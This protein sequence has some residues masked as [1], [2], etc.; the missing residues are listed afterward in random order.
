V[1]LRSEALLGGT[2]DVVEKQRRRR[3]RLASA[4]RLK[5]LMVPWLVRF[6]RKAPR[7]LALAPVALVLG[8]GRLLYFM[9]GNPLRR[10]AHDMAEICRAHGRNIA[11]Q[12]I[13]RGFLA[14]AR[15]LAELGLRLYRHGWQ[16]VIEDVQFPAEDIARIQALVE[17]Y[18][19]VAVAVPHNIGSTFS[20]IR[21]DKAFS[22]VL[23]S[24]NSASVERT[25]IALDFFE[26]LD[27]KVLM[28][29]DGSAIQIS[30]A[31]I[32]LLRSK[33][34]VAITMDRL[35]RPED[36]I[37]AQMFGQT[38]WFPGWASRIP[39]KVGAPVVP[40]YV[41]SVGRQLQGV[42]GPAVV[43]RDPVEATAQVAAFLERQII[44][45]P[46]SWAFLAEK[47]WGRVL[48][49]AAADLRR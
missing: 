12:T 22:S 9:P 28:V 6:M 36:G 46:A 45:D 26:R 15:A 29:R 3:R 33:K 38:V 27:A 1:T 16:E 20:G 2:I 48:A 5:D 41:K 21:F 13:Y 17:Q 42:F 19:G 7:P 35:A 39:T 14:N 34:V 10:A 43:T 23:L 24:K 11:P 32:K 30:R 40:A 18:G 49:E 37:A 8:S 44:E 47:R 4:S 25:R 31:L